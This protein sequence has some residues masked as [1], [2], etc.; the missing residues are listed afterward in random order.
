LIGPRRARAG[1]S[2]LELLV[3]IV[4]IGILLSVAI[5]R[6]MV[7]SAKAE[8]YAMDQVLGSLRSGIQIRV[9][10]LIAT[11]RAGEIAALAGTNPMRR[12]AE[13]PPNYLGELF[14]P[15][16]A[17][18]QA[19]NWYFDTR[20]RALVYLVDN[21][22]FFDSALPPP[23]RAFFAIE[24]VFDDTDRNGRYDAGVDVM[25]GLRLAS[26]TDYAWRGA[27]R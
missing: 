19:G 2:L 25:R 17:V 8:R 18:L 4:L 6:L 21:E 3:V 7:M 23:A 15:D 1:F 20:E 11:N 26:R 13:L 5:D 16:P 12:L 24:P 14:G 9:A 22:Q 27:A 10:E